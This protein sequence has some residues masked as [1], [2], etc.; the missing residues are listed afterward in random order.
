M[1]ALFSKI[2]V[3]FG[4]VLIGVAVYAHWPHDPLPEGVQADRVEVYK[5]KGQMVLF[6]EGKELRRY[7]VALGRTAGRKDRALDGKTPEGQY[8][9]DSRY[10]EGSNY[11]SSLHLTY[12]NEE[13]LATAK[14]LGVDPG[15]GISIHGVRNDLWF[16]GRLQKLVNWTRGCVAVSNQEMA[17]LWR[18]LPDH[19]P[20]NIY[21]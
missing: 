8:T 3:A 15:G 2:S 12:P 17:E 10:G 7:D 1:A 9:I 19:I 21:P 5:S 13:D 16:V 14:A 4:V 6:R 20:V 18:V 11:Y